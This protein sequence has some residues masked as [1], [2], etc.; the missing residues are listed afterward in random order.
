MVA[1]QPTCLYPTHFGAV[2]DIESIAGQLLRHLDF[3]EALLESAAAGD[4]SEAEIVESCRRRIRDYLQGVLDA[5]GDLGQD[6]ATWALL[7]MD[8]ELNAQ[9]IAF[10]AEKRRR[11]AREAA[12]VNH[13]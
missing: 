9:G 1:A 4:Q 5:R 3:A 8:I 10:V 6:P 2:T 7:E 12:R 11:K 13:P